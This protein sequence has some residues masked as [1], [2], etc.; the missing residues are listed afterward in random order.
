[1]T[2]VP[3]RAGWLTGWDY[4]HR[5]LHGPDLP[6]NSLAAARAAIERGMG[7]ECDVQLSADRQAMVFHDWELD[8]LTD[9][10]GPT[11]RLDAAQLSA[12]PLAASRETIP[13]L[14]DFL[15][16]IAG[17]VPLLIEVKSKREMPVEP[18]C[19]E[20]AAALSA[21]RGQHAIMS[22][23]PRISRW[24]AVH[25]PDTLRG[26]VVTEE[27]DKGWYGDLKRRVAFSWGRAEFLAC[28]VRDFPSRFAA[29]VRRKR[30]PVLT[31]TV[32]TAALAARARQWAD[33]PIAE[34]EGIL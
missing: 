20:V 19:R 26:L 4:A 7:I 1:L 29:S 14:H 11:N 15:A 2:A 6:E 34:G 3:N 9:K 16:L 24:F 25:S 33:A 22:F 5:G 8:R 23:D 31:W 12:L 18:V 32:R 30:I 21:Y 13:S 27:H 17:R 28:D 10:D